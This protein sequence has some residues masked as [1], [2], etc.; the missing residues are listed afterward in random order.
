MEIEKNKYVIAGVIL[1]LIIV[2]IAGF[3]KFSATEKIENTEEKITFDD[4][5]LKELIDDDP[6]LGN[7]DAKLVV[8]EFSDFQCPFCR[9]F[10]V[11]SL[12]QF[13]KEYVETGK[14]MFV[15]RDFPLNFHPMAEISGEAAQ[16]ANDQGKF[17][18]LHDKIFDEQQ[19]R[20]TGTISYSEADLKKWAEEIGLNMDEF[21]AC[22]NE[23]KYKDE[24]NKDFDYG[25]KQGI[26]GTPG[27]YI[28]NR[29]TGKVKIIEGA[30][31]Y[32]QFKQIIE[33]MLEG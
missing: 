7:R 16:C 2:G 31:P 14:V 17:W 24:V 27:F 19:K 26:R 29:E 5:E 8:V 10:Y 32:A 22:L 28:Y 4:N 12:K 1:F 11:E 13:K 30:Y 21:N 9:K 23:G 6:Y 15:Y 25:Y 20:G 18:E 3:M 33:D